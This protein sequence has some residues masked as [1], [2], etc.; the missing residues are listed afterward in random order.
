M[1][2]EFQT[3]EGLMAKE[4]K[5]IKLDSILEG[6]AE[7]SS[8]SFEKGLALLEE[9]VSRVE[10]GSLPLDKAIEAYEQGVK[11]ASKLQAELQGAEEKLKLLKKSGSGKEVL[12]E[13]IEV[14]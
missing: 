8:L 13:E 12:T 2:I 3:N 10:S 14:K 11:L 5:E 1:E 4:T 6:K 9:L 7:L